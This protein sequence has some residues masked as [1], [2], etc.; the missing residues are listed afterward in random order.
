MCEIVG[1]T[2]SR[3]TTSVG[4]TTAET[5]TTAS[6][7]T[8]TAES[9]VTGTSFSCYDDWNCCMYSYTHRDSIC[10]ELICATFP[11]L[12]CNYTWYLACHLSMNVVRKMGK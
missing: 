9:T 10:V 6:V 5:L 7:G 4:T 8:T 12:L 2:T 11:E 3:E 1:T